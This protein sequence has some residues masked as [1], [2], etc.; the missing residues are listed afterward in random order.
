MKAELYNG[1]TLIE[2]TESTELLVLG[3]IGVKGP[4]PSAISFTNIA[5]AS[6]TGGAF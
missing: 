3:A 1:A 6:N 5:D 4:S 2:V